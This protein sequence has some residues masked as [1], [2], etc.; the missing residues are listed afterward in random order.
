MT[1]DGTENL[2]W[3]SSV[4][5]SHPGNIWLLTCNWSQSHISKISDEPV[6]TSFT[7]PLCLNPSAGHNRV[8]LCWRLIY[9]WWQIDKNANRARE[10][11]L[12]SVIKAVADQLLHHWHGRVCYQCYV[13]CVFFFRNSE[14]QKDGKGRLPLGHGEAP[15]TSIS[16]L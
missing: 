8:S 11:H 14:Y 16:L 5:C 12:S 15:I 9:K 4:S 7:I 13:E 2:S 10:K 3:H 6:E 1:V